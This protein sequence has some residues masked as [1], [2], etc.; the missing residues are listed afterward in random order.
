MQGRAG[1]GG[2]VDRRWKVLLAIGATVLV[3]DQATKLL[4]VEHLTPGIADAALG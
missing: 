4:A 3:A 2:S 1:Y